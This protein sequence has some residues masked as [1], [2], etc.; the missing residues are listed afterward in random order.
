[1]WNVYPLIKSGV[2]DLSIW[3]GPLDR[4]I[5]EANERRQSFA[6]EQLSKIPQKSNELKSNLGRLEKT[7]DKEKIWDIGDKIDQNSRMISFYVIMGTPSPKV[8]E[9]Y[10]R[11]IETL[12]KASEVLAKYPDLDLFS[13]F[14]RDRK[15][16]LIKTAKKYKL[17]VA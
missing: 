6:E 5:R 8:R 12:Q 9:H 17:E 11:V 10:G 7:T 4:A 15:S 13:K 16:N 2:I 14:S 3:E 1:M